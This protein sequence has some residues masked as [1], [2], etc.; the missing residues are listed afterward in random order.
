MPILFLVIALIGAAAGCILDGLWW[1]GALLINAALPTPDQAMALIIFCPC[2]AVVAV[3]LWIGFCF[4][5]D[6][7]F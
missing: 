5:V 7:V 3:A 1:S 6:A 2:L 4:I